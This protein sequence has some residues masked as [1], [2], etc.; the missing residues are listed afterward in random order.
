MT[1]FVIS[2]GHGK[3]IRG[4]SGCLDEV[5]EARRVVDRVA[6]LL[7][8][9]NEPVKVFHDNSSTSQS[10]N[11]STIVNYH[12]SQ[13]R[14]FDISVHFNAYQTTSKPMGTEVLYVT[15]Q[16]LAA[17]VSTAIASAIGLPNRGA[18]YRS[19]LKF[20][21]STKKPAILIEVCFVDSS[22]D[23]TNYQ[24][25]FD[26]VC[27]AIV[28]S[29]TGKTLPPINVVPSERP[30]D[31]PPPPLARFSGKCSYF[32]GPDDDGV[33]A[34]EGLAFIFDYSD[35]PHL[36]LPEQPPN[37]TGLAR[38]LN[39]GVHYVACRWNYN[40]TPK[41]ILARPSVQAAV[42]ASGRTFLAWPADWGPH[43]D[44]SRAVDLSP[45]LMDALG[46]KTDDFVEV[47]YPAS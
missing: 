38:R 22:A 45:G 23:A 8:S 3:L 16:A 19:D 12:N 26:S 10:Q 31:L 27:R 44:T 14:D 2:S 20:L 33:A 29:L 43:G 37:T 32:G 30:E 9:I 39:P 47:V 24:Q 15:Q 46:I 18:K 42:T 41:E 7:R 5:N 11:L 40:A 13:S 21:N 35:A 28:Q 36:F 4:A 1:S 25:K 6:E 17:K 34:N